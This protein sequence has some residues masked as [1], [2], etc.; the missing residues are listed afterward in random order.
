MPV[1][2]DATADTTNSVRTWSS[3]ASRPSLLA[4]RIWR[5]ESP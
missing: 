1:S 3:D 2:P 4:T 5:R